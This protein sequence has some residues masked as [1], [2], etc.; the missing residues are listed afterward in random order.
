MTESCGINSTLISLLRNSLRNKLNLHQS[1][2]LVEKWVLCGV[3]HYQIKW[4]LSIFI[5]CKRIFKSSLS[6]IDMSTGLDGRPFVTWQG[7]SMRRSCEKK[8]FEI[9]HSWFGI[10]SAYLNF[11]EAFYTSFHLLTAPLYILQHCGVCARKIWSAIFKLIN[12]LA[13]AVY[14]S[15][16][17]SKFIR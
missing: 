12:W 17:Q 10:L 5:M 13:K 2:L 11:K 7:F 14:N 8:L 1:F 16:T 4:T 9:F 15:K 6:P 3:V